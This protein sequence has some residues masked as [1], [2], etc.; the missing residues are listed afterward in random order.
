MLTHVIIGDIKFSHEVKAGLDFSTVTL[1]FLVI[2]Q[3]IGKN[4]QKLCTYLVFSQIFCQLKI[5]ILTPKPVLPFQL[6]VV[7][8][9]FTFSF[10]FT[11]HPLY[12]NFSDFCILH[13]TKRCHFPLCTFIYPVCCGMHR[14]RDQE[15]LLTAV[16]S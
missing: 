1:F 3:F 8:S 16:I 11:I 12:N 6:I 15:I 7:S 13:G 4:T 10:F 14:K 2:D 9:H 5:Q